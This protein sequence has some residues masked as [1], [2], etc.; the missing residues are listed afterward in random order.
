MNKP[1]PLIA[2]IGVTGL[3]GRTITQIM[4]EQS[5]FNPFILQGKVIGV[6]SDASVQA[7]EKKVKILES[8]IPIFTIEAALKCKP[9]IIIMSAGE[10]ISKQY[11]KQFLEVNPDAWVIDNSPQWRMDSDIPLTIPHLNWSP[12][13]KDRIIP[14]PNCVAI[15][16]ATAM[17]PLLKLGLR[18]AT[19]TVL[20][21]V[22]GAG[23]PGTIAF[24]EEMKSIPSKRYE[25]SPFQFQ[26][27]NNIQQATRVPEKSFTNIEEDKVT[28]EIKKI[29]HR[30]F[31]N[32]PIS[33]SCF[34]SGVLIGHWARV[35]VHVPAEVTWQ[36]MKGA[37]SMGELI[38][39][40]FESSDLFSVVGKDYAHVYDL[41]IDQG[42]KGRKYKVFEFTVV[43]DNLRL[44]A[45]STALLCVEKIIRKFY[46]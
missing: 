28:S 36:R 25:N 6:A 43:S 3:V 35:R 31:E 34:R 17:Y 30:K 18:Q 24:E 42:F 22:S 8:Q 7:G 44:G 38:K 26:S 5:F 1:L 29:F 41:R 14:V 15:M 37:F 11:A 16:L 27:F 19:A 46:K 13:K 20:Q 9:D 40:S 23:L 10:E 39:F 45:A 2:I 33:P 21:S 4:G 32:F 12:N